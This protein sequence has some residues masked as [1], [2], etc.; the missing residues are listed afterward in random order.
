MKNIY[1][2]LIIFIVFIFSC[3]IVNKNQ[4]ETENSDSEK[5]Y[6]TTNGKFLPDSNDDTAMVVINESQNL[7]NPATLVIKTNKECYTYKI[8]NVETNSFKH[9]KLLSV[10]FD[11]DK[12]DELLFFCEINGNGAT[13]VSALEI[14]DNKIEIKENFSER[15]DYSFLF[16]DNKKLQIINDTLP[17]KIDL[18]LSDLI[19]AENFDSNGN[20]IGVSEIKKL[21]ITNLDYKVDFNNILVSYSQPISIGTKFLGS[22]IVTLVWSTDSNRF[23]VSNIEIQGSM[24]DKTGLS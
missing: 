15:N 3:V 12:I 4:F 16:L 2:I 17:C 23:V 24:T 6:F 19:S 1:V 10:D 22:V 11:N 13:Y 5:I 9:G 8:S 7:M 21:P 20:Y 18:E 14:V